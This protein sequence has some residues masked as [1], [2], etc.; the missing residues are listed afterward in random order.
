[1]KEKRERIKAHQK[2]KRERIK[3]IVIVFSI[4]K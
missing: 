1:M 3:Y 2:K 4:S